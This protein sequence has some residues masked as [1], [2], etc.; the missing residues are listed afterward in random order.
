MTMNLGSDLLP[1]PLASF[2]IAQPTEVEEAA[3]L[4]STL[5]N[6]QARINRVA[7]TRRFRLQLNGVRL[8]QL[9]LC[10]NYYTTDTVEGPS[11]LEDGVI[12]AFGHSGRSI[13]HLDDTAVVGNRQT[14]ALLSTGQQLRGERPQDS[15]GIYLHAP[16]AALTERYR[17]LTGYEP[18]ESFAFE[19]VVDL[20]QGGG[21]AMLSAVKFVL[22]EL[23]RDPASLDRRIFRVGIEDMLLAALL[24]LPNRYSN[25][26]EQ[27]QQRAHLSRVVRLAEEYIEAHAG[28]A[29]SVSDL[30]RVCNCSQSALFQAFQNTRG[31]SPMQFLGEIRL[32]R[33]RQFLLS[34]DAHTVSA[35][36]FGAGFNHLGRFAG[37]YRK[38]F[39]ETPSETRRKSTYKHR[40]QS[41]SA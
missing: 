13:A 1:C 23:D 18:K 27:G 36:A 26:L 30:V 12:F 14:G 16:Q 24:G 17:E 28:D 8:G 22:Q 4:I 19:R 9:A 38:R 34:D 41:R 3:G 2:V 6:G 11:M 35:V 20:T 10:A 25:D 21:A 33:A 7:D 39:G 29:I 40:P 31:Y 37:A 32:R 5:L 15:I